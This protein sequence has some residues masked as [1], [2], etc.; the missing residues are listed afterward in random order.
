M[1]RNGRIYIR[2]KLLVALIAMLYV[3]IIEF[4]PE[5]VPFSIIVVESWK[6]AYFI[7]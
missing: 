3:C 4:A 6:Q 2:S 1:Q 5:N 7:W